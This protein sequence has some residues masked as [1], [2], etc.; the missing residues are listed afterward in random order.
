MKSAFITPILFIV[1][2]HLLTAC[3]SDPGGGSPSLSIMPQDCSLFITETIGLT[4]NGEIDPNSKVSWAATLGTILNNSQGTSATYT[5]PA[6]AGEAKIEATV[7]SG[8]SGG[9]KAI[10]VICHI[11]DPN[12]TA[13]SQTPAQKGHQSQNASPTVVI[14]EVMG[15]ACGDVDQ[16]KY[17]QY[18]ELYNFGDQ[19]V[20]VAGWK[21]YDEGASGTPDELTAWLNRSSIVFDNRY[22]LNSTVIP[23][24]G[25][26]VVV[27]PQFYDNPLGIPY[28]MPDGTVI[29][30]VAQSDTLGDDY[31]GIIADQNGYDTVTL[32]IGGAVIE[33]VVDTYG[34]PVIPSDYPVD[35]DDNRKDNIPMYLSECTSI[36]R[37]NPLLPD[38][39]SN[40]RHVL[41]GSPGEAPFK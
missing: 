17:L 24:K 27:S 1:A 31:F 33:I 39:E 2:S 35:I 28:R 13:Q 9:I 37:I 6:V 29:L 12:V 34:T 40:W 26:A 25:V 14:S 22:I 21:L 10:S 18:V 5:A 19:P 8:L 20:N 41:N 23:P 36:E 16:R 15:N 32:Y 11:I 7:T 30:T 38:S 4:L 3:A